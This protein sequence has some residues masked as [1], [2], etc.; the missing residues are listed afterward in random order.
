MHGGEPHID[1]RRNTLQQDINKLLATYRELLE[2]TARQ[3]E[4]IDGIPNQFASLESVIREYIY[5][6][7]RANDE[8]VKQL[9]TINQALLLIYGQQLHSTAAR[10]A[11][12]TIQIS[13]DRMDLLKMFK[14]ENENL[15]YAKL[16]IAQQGGELSAE[17]IWLKRRD[18][19][20]EAVEK[21]KQELDEL[22]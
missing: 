10:K 20:S 22:T 19:A 14:E 16:M 11:F 5:E 21:I 7:S 2:R 13:A 8:I 9:N 3:G 17:L 4:L 1:R 12:D 6:E 18:K 15:N